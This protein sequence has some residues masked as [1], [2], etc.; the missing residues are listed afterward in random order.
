MLERSEKMDFLDE[1]MNKVKREDLKN[2]LLILQNLSPHLKK[3]GL[4]LKKLCF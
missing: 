1:C 2:I 3:E 4:P